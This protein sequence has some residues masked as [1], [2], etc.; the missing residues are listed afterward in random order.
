MTVQKDQQI[1]KAPKG[2]EQGR[3]NIHQK[4]ASRSVPLNG[5][6]ACGRGPRHEE[7]GG[8][9]KGLPGKPFGFVGVLKIVQNQNVKDNDQDNADPNRNVQRDH[10]C[11]EHRV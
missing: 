11:I 7:G 6:P 2:F 1:P 5:R 3:Q 9:P 4:I 8:V 10:S